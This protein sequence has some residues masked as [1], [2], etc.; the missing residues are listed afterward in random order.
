MGLVNHLHDCARCARPVA[1]G[2]GRREQ[3][4][5]LLHMSENCLQQKPHEEAGVP[6]NFAAAAGEG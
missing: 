5:D 1:S 3:S 4:V 6:K 2:C